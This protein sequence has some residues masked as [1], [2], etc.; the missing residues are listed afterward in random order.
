MTKLI[1]EA[2]TISTP[3]MKHPVPESHNIL[4]YIKEL[5]YEKHRAIHRWQN[6]K[7]LLD[8]TYLNRLAHNLQTAIRR[9][10]NEAFTHYI[11]EL[12]TNNHSIWKAKDKFKRPVVPIPPLRKPDRSWASST[13]EKSILFVEHL[14]S[15]FTPNSD[16]NN[17]DVI[18]AYLNTPCQLS[19]P[20]RAFRPV[21][22]KKC[23][24][25][26]QSAQSTRTRSDSHHNTKEPPMKSYSTHNIHIQQH[27]LPLPL[28][29]SVEVRSN[30]YDIQTGK[31]PNRSDIV[32]THQPSAHNG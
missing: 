26:T 4:L 15:V 5:V 22:I 9:A 21:E 29:Y 17:D 30:R 19:L 28:S 12:S 3:A 20:F 8:K 11:T 25:P 31:T 2:A 1:Q 16:N 18:A 6:S 13:S 24:K 27:T 10:K 23:N 32:Y 7:N 14:A